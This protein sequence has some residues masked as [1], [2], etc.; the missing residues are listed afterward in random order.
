MST[1]RKLDVNEI[2]QREGMHAELSIK[3]PEDDAQKEQRLKI[4]FYTFIV[5]ELCPYV[6]A[7]MIVL[8]VAIYCMKVLF[9]GAGT[10]IERDR[11]WTAVIALLTGV[12]G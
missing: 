10:P 7:F 1:P 5:K 2:L 6:L 12:T 11:A 9:S 4:D 3:T 8:A